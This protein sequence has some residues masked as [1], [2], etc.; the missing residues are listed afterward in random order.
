MSSTLLN[1]S[2]FT[3]RVV[4]A[5][6]NE[7]PEPEKPEFSALIWAEIAEALIMRRIIEQGALGTTNE[8]SNEREISACGRGVFTDDVHVHRDCRGSN[9]FHQSLGGFVRLKMLLLADDACW[10]AECAHE[11][12]LYEKA[13]SYNRKQSEWLSAVTMWCTEC[14]HAKCF[15]ATRV[16]AAAAEKTTTARNT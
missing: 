7:R 8:N 13:G 15:K 5:S 16:S 2:A 9:I 4:P 3:V 12:I 1:Q 14:E 11:R 6:T 10:R